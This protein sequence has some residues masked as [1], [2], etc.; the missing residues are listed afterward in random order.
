MDKEDIDIDFVT[1][2]FKL[3]IATV[4][5]AF[6]RGQYSTKF[7]D[8]KPSNSTYLLITWHVSCLSIMWPCDLM[9]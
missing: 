8:C 2:N 6:S 9:L 5:S 3:N 7:E 1:L 4:Q